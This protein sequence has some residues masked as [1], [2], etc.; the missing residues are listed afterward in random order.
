[1]LTMGAAVTFPTSPRAVKAAPV[2]LSRRMSVEQAFDAIARSCKR[3]IAANEEGVARFHDVESLHQMRVGLRRLAAARTL[4][5][6]VIRVPSTIEHQ[7]DCLMDQLGPVRDWD[8]LAGATLERAGQAMPEEEVL[9]ALQRAVRERLPALHERAAAAVASGRLRELVDS[10]SQ[11]IDARGWREGLSSKE[12]LRLTLPVEDF[13]G[14]LM[15]K[16]NERL[17]RRGRQLRDADPRALHRVRIA[18]KRARYA[19]EFFACLY[20]DKQ[21]RPYIRALRRLQEEL[22]WLNDAAVARRLLDEL[23]ETCGAG[24]GSAL[25][26]G[27]LAG[28]GDGAGARVCTLW[29]DVAPL[30]PPH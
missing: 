14:A 18:A 10:F 11:W 30:R 9:L 28:A 12:R 21:V 1:M 5:S 4:F 27:Y 8:V 19:A 23:D 7:L 6:D 26:R 3:Q 16:E 20:P 29:K 2:K 13:A 24:E 22:G 17:L 15:A 25:L